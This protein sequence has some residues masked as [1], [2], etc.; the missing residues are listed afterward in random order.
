MRDFNYSEKIIASTRIENVVVTSEGRLDFDVVSDYK[1]D[2]GFEVSEARERGTKRHELPKVPGRTYVW[3][4]GGFIKAFS[5]HHWVKGIFKSNV[6]EKTITQ[7][8]PAAQLRLNK[9][10]DEFLKRIVEE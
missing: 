8:K 1:S 9:E 10:T 3:I 5:K 4:A 7:M 2:T 6:I